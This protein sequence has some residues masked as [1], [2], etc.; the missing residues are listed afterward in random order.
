MT[1]QYLTLTNQRIE[2]AIQALTVISNPYDALTPDEKGTVKRNYKFSPNI[3]YMVARNLINLR[4]ASKKREEARVALLTSI[5]GEGVQWND[6]TELKRQQFTKGFQQLLDET[7]E[8]RVFQVRFATDEVKEADVV[9]LKVCPIP[10]TVLA[11]LI[12]S[13][14]FVCVADDAGGG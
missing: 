6:A 10:N 13:Q 14:M 2:N 3:G 12:D 8:V 7:Q 5:I 4:E 9:N 1:P 11:D